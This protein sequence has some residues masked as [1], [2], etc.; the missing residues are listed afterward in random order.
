MI[1]MNEKHLQRLLREYVD[2]Y[3]ADRVHTQLRYAPKGRP[4]EFRP[5]SDA[6]IIE[7]PRVGV[8]G[9]FRSSHH[10][11]EWQEAV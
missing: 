3:N 11:W 9:S 10:R 2:Y 6:Q 4:T 1:V 7:L 5:S 8:L